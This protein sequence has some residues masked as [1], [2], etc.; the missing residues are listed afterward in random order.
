MLVHEPDDAQIHATC[1]KFDA[2]VQEEASLI[3]WNVWR[4]AQ[5][6]RYSTQPACLDALSAD[7]NLYNALKEAHASKNYHSIRNWGMI[8][9]YTRLTGL[10]ASSSAFPHEDP[11]EYPQ[12]SKIED[13]IR[14]FLQEIEGS[15]LQLVDGHISLPVW[16]PDGVSIGGTYRRHLTKLKI[17]A[18]KGRPS[19]L[20]HNW[21]RFKSDPI[22]KER[23]DNV[24]MPNNHTS[25]T[26]V[27]QPNAWSLMILKVSR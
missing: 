6:P 9:M 12:D 24:F 21:G 3:L 19:L 13:D 16:P 10:T 25:V 14:N 7:I 8:F 22:L 2:N 1:A 5:Q 15:I 17:P 4:F 11:G 23:L 27:P 20:L 18:L 26:L